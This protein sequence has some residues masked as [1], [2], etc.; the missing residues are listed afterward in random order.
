MGPSQ[1]MPNMPLI[2]APSTQSPVTPFTVNNT[3]IIRSLIPGE[4]SYTCAQPA[5][6]L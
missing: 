4:S 5:P 6:R 1:K 3:N 2:Q